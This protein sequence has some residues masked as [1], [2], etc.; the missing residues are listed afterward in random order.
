MAEIYHDAACQ[1]ILVMILINNQLSQFKQ[2]AVINNY[3]TT[4]LKSAA[5]ETVVYVK[6]YF[7]G[8]DRLI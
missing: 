2:V 5:V 3:M 4:D 1:Q 7:V 8:R 6:V